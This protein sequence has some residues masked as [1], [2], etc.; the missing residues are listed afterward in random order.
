[1]RVVVCVKQIPDGT[2][3]PRLD[4]STMRLDRTG[5]GTIDPMD[6]VGVEVALQLVRQAG[7]GQVEALTMGPGGR[8][9]APRRA[10]AMG[11][12]CAT[13]ITDRRLVGADVI[14]TAHVL[15]A[16]LQRRRFDIVIV[17]SESADGALGIMGPAL[18]ELLHMPALTFAAAAEWRAGRLRVTRSLDR[19]D[20][21]VEADAP[22]L[23][24]VTMAAAQASTP[25]LEG[26][27]GAGRKPLETVDLD[28]LGMGGMTPF[29][30]R[31]SVVWS[32]PVSN[33]AGRGELHP[34]DEYA[35]RR[36]ADLL[37]ARMPR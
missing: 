22:A 14:T 20:E 33:R 34:D 1:M 12:A 32:G 31:Q 19:G 28:Q 30:V 8:L 13:V 29:A 37:A 18:A 6:G 24:T 25:T 11:A 21:L 9:E 27:L 2:P 36:I 3:P 15:A 26:I 23:I 7:G 17:G 16:A 4:T 35:G 10:L 5:P